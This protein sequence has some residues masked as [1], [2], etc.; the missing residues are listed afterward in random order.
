MVHPQDVIRRFGG[1]GAL[2]ATRHQQAH[3]Q[4]VT[5]TVCSLNTARRARALVYGCPRLLY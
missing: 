3:S 5:D 2:T 1:M 4:L